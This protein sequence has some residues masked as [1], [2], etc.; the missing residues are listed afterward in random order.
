V[1]LTKQE[2]K[3]LK[4]KEREEKELLENVGLAPKWAGWPPSGLIKGIF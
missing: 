4:E 1:R 3:A 2:K